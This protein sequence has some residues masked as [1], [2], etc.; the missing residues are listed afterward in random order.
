MAFHIIFWIIIALVVLPLAGKLFNALGLF[1]LFSR[2]NS[3]NRRG[4]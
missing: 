4:Y 2:G 1:A 3:R